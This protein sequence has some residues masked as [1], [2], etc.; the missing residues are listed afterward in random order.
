MKDKIKVI[1]VDDHDLVRNGI[2]ALLVKV[3]EVQ[4]IGEAGSFK[5]LK[6]SLQTCKPHLILLDINLPGISG[7]EAVRILKPDYPGVRFLMLSMYTN[8]EFVFNAVKVGADGYLPKNTTVKELRDA[9]FDIYYGKVYF[10]KSIS[11][12]VFLEMMRRTRV[13]VSKPEGGQLTRREKEILT[14]VVEGKT[15]PQIANHLCISI[16]TVEAHK[17]NILK[18]L[19]VSNSVELVKYAIKHNIVNL[20]T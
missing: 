4:V 20:D 15:N 10:S 16:R 18:K 1:I 7:I 11:E 9:I 3:P 5:D 2:K 14:Y 19:G 13:G 17:T 8:E 12:K 6:I